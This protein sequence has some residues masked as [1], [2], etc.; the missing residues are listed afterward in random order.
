MKKLI[1]SLRP[2]KTRADQTKRRLKTLESEHGFGTIEVVIIIAVMLTVVFLF[3]TEISS[4]AS[5]LIDH[6]FS[7][8]IIE[9][10]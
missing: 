6:V 7:D 3:R 9:S 1:G 4:F 2:K 8:S 10:L 5:N